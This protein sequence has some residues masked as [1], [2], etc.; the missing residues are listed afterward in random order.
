MIKRLMKKFMPL[1]IA[2]MLLL[3]A[4]VPSMAI[5]EKEGKI[6][7]TNLAEGDKAS[8]YKIIG[9]NYDYTADMPVSPEFIWKSGTIA[10]FVRGSYPSYI[11]TDDSVTAAYASLEAAEAKRAFN[12]ALTQQVLSDG[13]ITPDAEMAVS[14]G[15]TSLEITG[16]DMGSYLVI[17][18]GSNRIYQPIVVNIVPEYIGDKWTISNGTLSD[19][20][21]AAKY[22]TPSL[23]HE[24]VSGSKTAK[25]GEIVEFK[26]VFDVPQLS[27]GSSNHT[28]WV[29]DTMDSGLFLQTETISVKGIS[30]AGDETALTAGTDYAVNPDPALPGT[31]GSSFVVS[32]SDYERIS[33]YT[34]I[35]ITYSAEVTINAAD[36]ISNAA[37]IR[38]TAKLHYYT[39]GSPVSPIEAGVVL[40]TYGI[41]VTKTG[42]N[43]EVLSGAAFK[44]YVDNG[45]GVQEDNLIEFIDTMQGIYR[46]ITNSD[47]LSEFF[48]VTSELKTNSTG[49]IRIDG[50]STGKYLIVESKAPDGYINLSEPVA[51]EIKDE[52][53]DAGVAA[54][55]GKPEDGEGADFENGYVPVTVQ[56][57]RGMTL[58]VTGGVGTLIFAA[59]GVV[60]IGGGV[61]VFIVLIRR[62][63]RKSAGR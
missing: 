62:A 21:I 56:N 31:E 45:N 54:P 48:S 20:E 3:S 52:T 24:T 36:T 61:T 15:E 34:Q 57:S 16:L 26:I 18:K 4:A 55:N 43:S 10:D 17:I 51:L 5:Q 1:C 32:F 19:K 14:A 53:G 49:L 40:Y 46:P 12:T 28:V 39:N 41:E 2:V 29:S 47:R 38:S 9:V 59:I 60:L 13:S 22:S 30:L 50:L 63:R 11:G 8:V 37:G 42:D 33:S 58:P 25:I 6:S 35:V 7:L 23:T 27:I 44:L